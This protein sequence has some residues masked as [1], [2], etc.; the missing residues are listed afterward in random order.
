[1]RHRVV[2]AIDF[3]V[4]VDVDLGVLPLAVDEAP[5]R[6]GLEHRTVEALEH[7][8]AARTVDPHGP[9]IQVLQQFGNALVERRQ[10]EMS[11][12][13]QARDNPS[14]HH[15]YGVFGFR[16]VLRML[17]SRRQYH[18]AVVSGPLFVRALDRRFVPAWNAHAGAKLV[19]DECLRRPTEVPHRVRVARDPIGTTLGPGRFCVGVI[20]GAQ[21]RH[22]QLDLGALAEPSQCLGAPLPAIPWPHPPGENAAARPH[23][24]GDRHPAILDSARRTACTRTRRAAAP[25]TPR[26]AAATSPPLLGVLDGSKRSRA[27]VELTPPSTGTAAPPA[28]SVLKH[29]P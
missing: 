21:H 10:G 11:L 28:R 9:P 5:V 23:E 18:R 15:T 7:F 4:V 6:Q 16:L 24:P 14:L 26:E 3:D 19:A 8:L 1:M 20:R 25:G 29:R 2:V 27:V 13:A 22:E 17:R 12:V